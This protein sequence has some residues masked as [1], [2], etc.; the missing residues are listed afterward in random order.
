MGLCRGAASKLNFCSEPPE[1]NVSAEP[2]T[3]DT[4]EAL[5]LCAFAPPDSPLDRCL[6]FCL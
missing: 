5:L 6:S 4:V 3:K 2:C 1:K